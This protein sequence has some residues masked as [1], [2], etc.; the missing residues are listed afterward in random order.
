MWTRKGSKGSLNY[1]MAEKR[2][3]EKRGREIRRIGDILYIADLGLALS[4]A[5][6]DVIAK[7]V[8][9]DQASFLLI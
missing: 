1:L 8:S 4:V 5:Q 6:P 7:A 3:G 9:E 2:N